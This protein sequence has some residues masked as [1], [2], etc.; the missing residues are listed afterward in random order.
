LNMIIRWGFRISDLVLRGVWEAL[1][2][3]IVHN[4][5]D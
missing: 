1:S 5:W 2:R 4:I 3:S